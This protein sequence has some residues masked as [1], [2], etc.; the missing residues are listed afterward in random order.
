[1]KI[2]PKCGKEGDTNFCAECGMP[3]VEKSDDSIIAESNAIE[4]PQARLRGFFTKEKRK[5]NV[6]LIVIFVVVIGIICAAIA[7]IYSGKTNLEIMG[8]LTYKYSSGLESNLDYDDGDYK[9]E[10]EGSTSEGEYVIATGYIKCDSSEVA[11]EALEQT[12]SANEYVYNEDIKNNFIDVDGNKGR[13]FT[14]KNEDGEVYYIM[15]VVHNTRIFMIVSYDYEQA[16]C[17]DDIKRMV[18]SINFES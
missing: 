15:G 5:R 7:M 10:Y 6:M 9:A 16:A 4:S 17:R 1:M 14:A 8:D 12:F 18:K 13:V 2:C 11:Q 3:M